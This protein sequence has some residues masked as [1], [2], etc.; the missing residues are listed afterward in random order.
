MEKK[1]II[2]TDEHEFHAFLDG[3]YYKTGHLDIPRYLIYCR[4]CGEPREVSGETAQKPLL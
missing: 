1:Q 4:K 3:K 2:C